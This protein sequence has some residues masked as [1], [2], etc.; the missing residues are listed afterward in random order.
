MRAITP[1]KEQKSASRRDAEIM[2]GCVVLGLVL[3]IGLATAGD[4]GITIDEFNTEDYGPKAL[5]WYLSGF[6]DRSQFAF[7]EMAMYGPW[8]QMLIAAVQSL[9]LASPLTVRHAVTFVIGLAGIAALLPLGRLV[10]G[11]WVGLTAVVLCLITGYLYGLLFFAPIDTPFL[12]AMCWSILAIVIMVRRDVPSWRATIVTG[13]TIGLALGIRTGGVIALAYLLGA[14][15]LAA[16]ELVLRQGRRAAPSVLQIALR[17]FSVAAIACLVAFALWPWLQ[18]GNPLSQFAKAYA[19]FAK[20]QLVMGFPSW[21]R[22]LSTTALPWHYIAEQLLARLPELFILLL[23]VAFGAGLTNFA[24]LIRKSAA[25]YARSGLAGLKAPA[26]WLARSRGLLVVL[27]AAIAPG[28]IIVLTRMSHYDGVRHVLFTIP[29]LAI[30][31]GWG[32]KQIAPLIVRF[33][34]TAAALAGAQVA[35]SIAVMAMLHP[36]EYVATNAFAGGAW[37]SHG[38]FE[39]DFW[40]AAGTEA[41]RRL[42]QRLRA[43]PTLAAAAPPRVVTCIPWR[44]HDMGKVYPLGWIVE[45]DPSKAQ[46]LIETERYR[47]AQGRDAML[48]DEV[49]R[50]GQAFAWTYIAKPR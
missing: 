18:I 9:K 24:S 12:A 45:T 19:H 49:K 11:R 48:I 43:D 6:T 15:A 33:P 8:A 28:A 50:L 44:E 16:L 20:I 10:A 41:V 29:M 23:L 40:S 13:L 3:V 27:V 26:V 47:C 4:Y 5:A 34:K 2:I 7:E 31:A 1:L 25:R 35:Y 21:G 22:E 30:L 36:L 14:L 39:L 17:F 32:G 46:F 42:E 37:R 38:R